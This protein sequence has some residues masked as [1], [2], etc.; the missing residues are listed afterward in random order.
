M[1]GDKLIGLLYNDKDVMTYIE[2]GEHSSNAYF[3]SI[4]NDDDNFNVGERTGVTGKGKQ[5]SVLKTLKIVEPT[6]EQVKKNSK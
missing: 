2:S 6:T 4:L 5:N 3:S 1:R